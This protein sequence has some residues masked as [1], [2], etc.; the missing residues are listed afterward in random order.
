MIDLRVMPPKRKIQDENYK[1]MFSKS[2]W[3]HKKMPR[4]LFSS[5]KKV[6]YFGC[7]VFKY[8]FLDKR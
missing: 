7:N 3:R 8:M 1:W 2:L 4:K 6:I 5:G